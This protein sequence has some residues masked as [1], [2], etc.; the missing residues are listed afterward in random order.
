RAEESGDSDVRILGALLAPLGTFASMDLVGQ[1][2]G[3][4]FGGFEQFGYVTRTETIFDE[5]FHDR[6][7][8][9]LGLT[10]YA[11]ALIIKV[12]MLAKALR[13]ALVARTEAIRHW[14]LAAFCCQL[15]SIWQ[16]PVYNS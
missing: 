15:G 12:A 2:L 9:E 8:I 10:G 14:A 13:L 1:G 3:T 5:V 4:S 11:L 16:V 6:I 7:G